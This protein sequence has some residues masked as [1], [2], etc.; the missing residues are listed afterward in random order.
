MAASAGTQPVPPVTQR[1]PLEPFLKSF[2][3]VTKYTYCTPPD[4]VAK[5]LPLPTVSGGYREEKPDALPAYKMERPMQMQTH[6]S[7]SVWQT[8]PSPF[9]NRWIGSKGLEAPV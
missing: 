5:Y 4:P 7:M 6:L 1:A 8:K 2:L 3:R 9:I